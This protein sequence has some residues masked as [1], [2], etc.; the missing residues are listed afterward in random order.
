VERDHRGLMAM[1][2]FEQSLTTAGA[3]SGGTQIPKTTPT[4]AVTV[5]TRSPPPSNELVRGA[6]LF[7]EWLE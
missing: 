6:R 1:A 5:T 2:Q 4:V 7:S 3:P